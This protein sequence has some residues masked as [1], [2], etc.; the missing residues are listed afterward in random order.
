MFETQDTSASAGSTS[1]D[2]EQRNKT[3][4]NNNL[5]T[6][7][8]IGG[9]SELR[10]SGPSPLLQLS[11]TNDPQDRI[12]ISSAGLADNR[13]EFHIRERYL[14]RP[15]PQNTQTSTGYV[16]PRPFLPPRPSSS[17]WTPAAL[18]AESRLRLN[19]SPYSTSNSPPGPPHF[20]YKQQQPQRPQ[21]QQPLPP[22]ATFGSDIRI[23]PN[24]P[25][26]TVPQQSTTSISHA[27][28]AGRQYIIPSTVVK[29]QEP[30]LA[31][32]S[33][34]S[35]TWR[36]VGDS[37]R[38][39]PP[40]SMPCATPTLIQPTPCA[41][42]VGP[43]CD[44]Q[45]QVLPSH[46]HLGSLIQL[47]NGDLKRVESL[48][49]EDF[50]RSAKSSPEVKIDQSTV[51]A[52][53]PCKE[54]GTV[55]ITFSVGKDNV[56]VAV[57]ATVEH[58][59]YAIGHGWSSSSPNRSLAKFQLPCH[60]LKVGDICISL[61]QCNNNN[62]N[63]S[64]TATAS[65]TSSEAEQMRPPPP[66]H[67]LNE[68]RRSNSASPSDKLLLKRAAAASYAGL[69]G[70]GAGAAA[71]SLTTNCPSPLAGRPKSSTLGFQSPTKQVAFADEANITTTTARQQSDTQMPPVKKRKI[72]DV[73]AGGNSR[74]IDN[75]GP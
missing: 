26:S 67:E 72:I 42:G 19:Y 46:F 11:S 43:S 65:A 3:P 41:L 18:E 55:M 54:R 36:L 45:N 22:A 9:P 58:P 5:R 74:D 7:G 52:I 16:E 15:S 51:T 35:Q 29:Q 17:N 21:P 44:T 50:I 32:V 8:G 28:V 73:S 30:D 23:L 70:L 75:T 1:V 47:T 48:S 6:S 63:G 14:S 25:F 27:D 69:S 59:F 71:G 37:S 34:P 62:N 68:R 2:H 60:Q 56:K 13:D 31:S 49:T 33:Q 39:R 12:G 64:I 40:T 4:N 53:E 57:E 66:P 20:Y 61:S 38:P 10:V 24:K